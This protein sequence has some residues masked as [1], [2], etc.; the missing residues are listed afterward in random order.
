M[1]D[2][3]SIPLSGRS[4]GVGNGSPLRYS[5]LENSMNSYMVGCSSWGCKEWDTT[6]QLSTYSLIPY[7]DKEHHQSLPPQENHRS[8]LN[9][10]ELPVYEII[11]HIFFCAWLLLPYVV[12]DG[13]GGLV[14][15]DSWGRKESDT[16]ERLI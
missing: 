16:T 2:V 8:I 3:G 4:S 11:P 1:G 13:Q 14:C 10:L 15:C 5:C 7:L 6:E 9:V 12:G